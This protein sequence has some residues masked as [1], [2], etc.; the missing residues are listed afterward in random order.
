MKNAVFGEEKYRSDFLRGRT[1]IVKNFTI[2]RNRPAPLQ[3]TKVVTRY[4]G[5]GVEC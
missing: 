2:S 4:G 3:H 5:R 1:A